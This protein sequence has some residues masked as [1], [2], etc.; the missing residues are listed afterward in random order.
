MA[1][2][3][4]V[5]SMLDMAEEVYDG[6]RESQKEIVSMCFTADLCS[7]VDVTYELV[8][9][10]PMVDARVV[11]YYETTGKIPQQKAIAKRLGKEAT[12]VCRVYSSY[13]SRLGSALGVAS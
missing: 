8:S 1:E 4:D 2:H 5:E 11:E 10:Y 3:G 13:K 12:A 7:A 6:L 9:R